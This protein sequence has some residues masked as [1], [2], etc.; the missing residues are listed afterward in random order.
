MATNID[1]S[2]YQAPMGLEAAAA[3][4]PIEIEIVD[5]EEVTIGMDGVEIRMTKGEP[6]DEDFDA[7]LAEFMEEGE[8]H[9]MAGDLC[10][11]IDN[12]KNSRKDWEQTYVDG[13]KLL[14]L[15]YEDRTEPWNGACG[16]VHPLIT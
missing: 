11:E 8:M 13:L 9:A 14:G 12:D 15:K 2:L 7:N 5:P 3:Q 6:S 10:T 1:K 4:E 16:V